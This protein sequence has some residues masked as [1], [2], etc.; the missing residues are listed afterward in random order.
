M[1]FKSLPIQEPRSKYSA[2]ACAGKYETII[3]STS[4]IFKFNPTPIHTLWLILQQSSDPRR[5]QGKRHALPIILLIAILSLC[6]GAGSYQAMSEWA[7]NYQD[8]LKEELPFLASHTPSKSTFHRVFAV[9]DAKELEKIFGKW[10]QTITHLEKHEGIAIDGKAIKNTDLYLV[11]TFAHQ[12]K[13]TLFQQATTGKGKELVI[14]PQVLSQ[15]DLIDKIVTGDALFT[16]RNLCQQITD[17]QGGYVFTVKDNQLTLREGIMNYFEDSIWQTAYGRRICD[18][19]TTT[20][21][22][23]H[24]G[25]VEERTYQVTDNSE[26]LEYLNWPGLTHVWKVIRKVTDKRTGRTSVQIEYGV[27]RLLDKQ[28]TSSDHLAQL[29]R[30]HWQIENNSHRIRDVV[31]NEDKSTIR[32]GSGPQVIAALTNLVIGIFN[33]GMVK[34]FPTANRRFAARPEELFAFW[35]LYRQQQLAFLTA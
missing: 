14:A 26:L 19:Q 31:W 35:G 3:L 7:V 27:A 33:R 22:D 25:R 5:R 10:L 24:K 4:P 1:T 11:S 17:R 16:Q 9:L 20:T 21:C 23:A 32:T 34:S 2:P 6:C 29:L 13:T 12:A 28:T 18:I 15:I 30:G 8:R